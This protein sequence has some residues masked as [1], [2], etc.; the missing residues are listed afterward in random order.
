MGRNN[1]NN[2]EGHSSRHG[3]GNDRGGRGRCRF[4][5][6]TKNHNNNDEKQQEMKFY[7]HG[8][9][10]KGQTVTFATVKDHIVSFV[11]HTYKH[12]KDIGISLRELEKID[13]NN[14]RPVRTIS[15]ETDENIRKLEQLFFRGIP[16]K[17]DPQQPT[18]R[19]TLPSP[20]VRS[21][22]RCQTG[23]K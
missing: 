22:V 10:K 11:Q 3:R 2:N 4:Q 19:S 23:L 9:G 6:K 12:G 16:E 15:T 20:F 13:L 18:H 17:H 21:E 1:N 8:S 7:P 5:S 14:Y